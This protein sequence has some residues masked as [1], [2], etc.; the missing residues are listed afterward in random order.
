MDQTPGGRRREPLGHRL[1]GLWS[2]SSGESK[3][4][5]PVDHYVRIDERGKNPHVF[6]GRQLARCWLAA[7]RTLRSK[8]APGAIRSGATR[9]SWASAGAQRENRAREEKRGHRP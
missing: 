5:W 4:Y 2:A 3:C 1:E 9:F 7:V 8:S 6:L